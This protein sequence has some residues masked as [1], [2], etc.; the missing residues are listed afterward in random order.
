MNFQS[1]SEGLT[2]VIGLTEE[3]E[4][5]YI[6]NLYDTKTSNILVVTS[7]LYEANKFYNLV[8]KYT[9]D[10][11]LFPMDEFIT[12][13]A[14]ISSPE[15]EITRLE[16]LNTI[17]NNKSKK[18]IITNLM[19]LLRYLPQKQKYQENMIHITVDSE[20][21][22][23]ELYRRLC[24]S[25]YKPE[26]LV[27]KTGEISSRGY[28]LDVFPVNEENAVRIE[29]WGDVIES[30]RYF[31]INSQLS[32]KEVKEITINP[33]SEFLT[34]KDLDEEERKQKYLYKYEK[35][36][37][38]TEYLDSP[39]LIYKEYSQIYNSYLNLQ[40]EIHNYNLETKQNEKYMFLLE[41]F[42][43][44][45]EIYISSVDSILPNVKIDFTHIY[46]SHDAPNFDDNVNLL[47]E[48]IREYIGLN[49]TV[50]MSLDSESQYNNVV[51]FL[52]SKFIKTDINNIRKNALN[53]IIHPITKGYIF[54]NY[55]VL[56]SSNLFKN[57][58]SKNIYKSK[59]KYGT[60]I[61]SINSLNI[62]DYVVHN[63]HGIGVYQGIVALK[64][65]NI[66][67]DYLQIRYKDDG[68]LYIPVEKIELISKYSSNDS[69]Q[70]KLNKLGSTE[71]QKTKL[72]VQKKL[73]DIADEILKIAIIRRTTN[74]FAFKKDLPEQLVFENEFQYE[75][76]ED[77]LKAVQQIKIEME[78]NSPMDMLL[79]GDV[80]YG[81]TEVAFRAMFKA[82]CSNK[83]VAYLCPTT[84]LSNQ[85]YNSALTRF[86]N[87]PVNIALLNRFTS[88]KDAEKIVSDLKEGKIDILFGT[89]RILSNDIAFKDIGLLVVDEEQRFGVTHKEKIKKY[90]AN[91]D[92]LTLSATPIPRTLQMS[93]VGLRSLCLIETPPFNRYPVQTYVL[94]ENDYIIKDAIYKE[95]SR[96]GQV[97]IL[98]NRIDSFEKRINDLVRLI[99]DIK[100]GYAHG[101]MNKNEIEDIMFKFINK[102]FNVLLCT[103]II[104]TGIDI[105]NVNTLII[106]DADKF[107][108]S[109]LYQIRGRVGRSNKVAYAYLMYEK[110]K[111]LSEIATKRLSAI[112]EFAQLGSGFSIAMRDL[113]IRGA[114]SVLGSEQSGFIDTIG[115]EL[116]LKMLNEEI[117][118]ITGK[119]NYDNNDEEEQVSLNVETHIDDSY[120]NDDNLKIEIHKIINQI[121]SLDSLNTARRKI[122]DRF[123]KISEN[124][125]IYM[126]EELF[127]SMRKKKG[128]EIVKQTDKYIELSFSKDYSNRIKADELFINAYKISRNFKLSY[129]N[130][131]IVLTLSITNLDK[132]FIY[133]IVDLLNNL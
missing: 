40:E 78:K 123:G 77:Q 41:E 86:K 63:M 15:L 21:N 131:R 132:H 31:D 22:K 36:S 104:E 93:M 107:G 110:K 83:Q 37:K 59:F 87:F 29:F 44:K 17:V 39:I 128:I 74:G 119:S 18:I 16:T 113:S 106:L 130:S 55:V 99:P 51:R 25:G 66:V 71:W 96:G 126:Y 52:S 11:Y 103:T 50:I 61:S 108:L 5:I 23:E 97:Y 115:I 53:I 133:Y 125:E 129:V 1:V 30:I 95:L 9:N 34:D 56:A 118:K 60:K 62:G 112:K 79:C 120:V 65:G 20:V 19:G 33:F 111:I 82:I 114:G 57:V 81:K 47:N 2:N 67:K 85:Q 101:R 84:I 45:C 3:L 35:I 116:Y 4:S 13:E 48:K 32:I 76:T 102:E 72:R 43:E 24:N 91:I 90:K 88:K 28:I 94:E 58:S 73:K 70:P 98:C 124:L 46:D 26:T 105:P 38:L 7:T 69:I 12:S 64:K 121:D 27:T 14:S 117:D 42:S 92:V 122:E 10:V 109:Q 75:E 127:E 80:G 8:L 100:I 49:K 6:K 68:K 54:D 89:H